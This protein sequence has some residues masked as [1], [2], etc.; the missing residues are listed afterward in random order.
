M[1][2]AGLTDSFRAETMWGGIHLPQHEYFMALYTDSEG[3]VLGAETM[4]YE[5]TGEVQGLGYDP[6][7]QMLKGRKVQLLERVVCLDFMSPVWPVAT[8]R[9]VAGG[10]IYN[11][12]LPDKNSVCVVDFGGFFTSINGP[13]VARLPEPGPQTSLVQWA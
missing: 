3:A 1:I 9:D 10:L 13:F 4:Q 8:I 7:G 2:E 12:S 11:G 5:P 6:G